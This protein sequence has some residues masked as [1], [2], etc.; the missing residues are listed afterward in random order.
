MTNR[1][2]VT[3]GASGI[4]RAMVGAFWPNLLHRC[5]EH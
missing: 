2:I 1:V 4:G 5:L 3:A